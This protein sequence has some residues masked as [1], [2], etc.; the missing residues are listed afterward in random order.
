M[1][2]LNPQKN[3][4][5]P[6]E[7]NGVIKMSNKKDKPISIKSDEDIVTKLRALAK[8][9]RNDVVLFPNKT[10]KDA[11]KDKPPHGIMFPI[12]LGKL[13]QFIADMAE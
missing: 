7:K 11:I 12:N 9:A 13:L 1:W 8:E 5:Y 6:K 10:F 3:S 4:F 2:R